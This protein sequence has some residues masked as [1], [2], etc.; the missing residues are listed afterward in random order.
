MLA[1]AVGGC[2]PQQRKKDELSRHA[3]VVECPRCRKAPEDMMHRIWLC[4]SNVKKDAYT[5]SDDLI[6]Q[7]L[8]QGEA[9]QGFWLRGLMP[10]PW[11]EVPPP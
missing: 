2:W 11:T 9:N 4:E 10:A 3:G 7:A 1:C 8:A 6:P 5:E